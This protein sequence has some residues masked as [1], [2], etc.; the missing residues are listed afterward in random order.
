MKLTMAGTIA[1][2]A[3]L[4]LSVLFA[5]WGF[6]TYSQRVNWTN[7]K[8]GDRE[9]EYAK[10]DAQIKQ[11]NTARGRVEQRWARSL[12]SPGAVLAL[13]ASRPQHQEWYQHQ[14]EILKTGDAN[15]QL[16]AIVS[17]QGQIQLDANGYPRTIALTDRAKKPMRSLRLLNED[18][19]RIQKEIVRVTGEIEKLV[20]QEK[21]LTEQLGDGQARGLRF[22][23]AQQQLAEKRS[24]DEQDYLQPLL[25]NS[26]VEQRSLE[27]RHKMLEDR[28]KQLQQMAVAK[29]P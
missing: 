8:L 26:M 2:F 13:E 3:N 17:D 15:Q 11:L 10:R 29:Q 16:P 19:G 27:D 4:A 20:Q 14:I 1:L 22:E 12:K 6:A 23:L 21:D 9:A 28:V 24:L 18:Y 7:K 25:Y 5:F